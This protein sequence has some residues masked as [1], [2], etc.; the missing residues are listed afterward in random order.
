[1]RA[2][3]QLCVANYQQKLLLRQRGVEM[4]M[5]MEMRWMCAGERIGGNQ[6]GATVML[7]D[8][9]KKCCI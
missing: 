7:M 6:M 5:E 3:I 9:R 8:R 4:Q 2:G 1:M